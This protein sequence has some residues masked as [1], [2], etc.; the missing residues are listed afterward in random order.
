MQSFSLIAIV[1]AAAI[2]VVSAQTAAQTANDIK[3]LQYALTL[4]NLE[5]TFYNTFQALYNESA[6]VAAGYPAYVYDYLNVVQQHEN[7]HVLLLSTA[8]G[9]AAVPACTYNFSMVTSV[10]TYLATSSLLENTGVSAYD[11]AIDDITSPIY[12]TIAAEIVTVEARHAAFVLGVLGMVPFPNV[13]DVPLNSSVV[14]AGITPFLVNCS[15]NVAAILPS[16]R[17][18]G[19]GLNATGSPVLT[20]PQVPGI[21][22]ATYTAAQQL[23]DINALNYALTLEN[24]EATFYNTY[25]PLFNTTAFVSA[26]LNATDHTYFT[27]IQAHENAHVTALNSTILARTGRP[28]VAPCPAY[29][30][31]NITTV[32]QFVAVARALENTGVRAYD[33]AVNTILDT[34]LQV[35]AATVATVEGRHASYL[36]GLFNFSLPFPSSLDNATLPSVILPIAA[37]FISGACPQATGLVLPQA[38]TLTTVI[39]DPSFVGFNGEHYQV[40]GIEGK[41]FNLIT[42]ETFQMN[43]LFGLLEAGQTMTSA[44]MKRAQSMNIAARLNA[45]KTGKAMPAPLPVTAAWSHDGTYLTEIGIK[46]GAHQ[47]Q[48]IAGEYAQGLVATVDGRVITPSSTPIVFANGMSITLATAHAIDITHPL[49][50]LTIANSDKFFNI[51]AAALS[52]TADVSKI[53]GLLGQSAHPSFKVQNTAEFRYHI[54]YDYLIQTD[55]L[56]DDDFVENKFVS[57]L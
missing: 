25:V 43:A 37:S 19:V 30:F 36:N 23:N 11:G 7:A 53:N 12:Q 52:L 28:G 56:F 57:A 17:P 15:Y 6:F 9:A 47:I 26:G 18:G 4:E 48:L 44:Q 54:V 42:A 46:L 22:P 31:G 27:I 41:I 14:A 16:I 13:L 51:D 50:S 45:K 40:H 10:A 32:A 24:L 21:T 2:A 39:G 49:L 20:G 55:S 29:N 38:V 34:G 1:L 8:L 5:A 33:G 35:V 3:T